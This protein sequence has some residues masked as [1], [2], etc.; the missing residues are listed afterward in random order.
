MIVDIFNLLF[1]QPL[2]NGL[3]FLLSVLPGA[4]VGVAVI[5]LTLLV[6]ITIFPL[7][8]KSV[9][10]Q[11]KIRSI[12]PEVKKIKKEYGKDKQEQA[13][14]VMELYKKHGVN[15]F[16]GC[17]LMLAQLPIILALYWVFFKGLGK[18]DTTVLYSFVELPAVLNMKFLGLFDMADKS[19]IIAL[20]AGVTQYFQMKLSLPPQAKRGAKENNGSGSFKDEFAKNMSMQMRYVLPVFVFFIAYTISAAVAL[21][22]LTSNMFSIGHELIVR[23]K[24]RELIKK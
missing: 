6:K 20:F 22:W 13:R 24:A 4:D 21:Y 7:S 12:D 11:A 19:V 17:L 14:K 1:Y 23:K 9:K 16:S 8:H 10:S 2:Y 3:V 18:L 15:P 5:L